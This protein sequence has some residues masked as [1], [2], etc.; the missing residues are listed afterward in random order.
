MNFS[1]HL[2]VG[3]VNGHPAVFLCCEM[4]TVVGVDSSPCLRMIFIYFMGRNRAF[5]NV[6]R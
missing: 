5:I 3:L 6:N 2:F 4:Y 1:S